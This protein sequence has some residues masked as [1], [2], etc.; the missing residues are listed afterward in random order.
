MALSSIW[1]SASLA[2]RQISLL[3]LVLS[4][5]GSLQLSYLGQ[6]DSGL[7]AQAPEGLGLD[8]TDRCGTDLDFKFWNQL[9]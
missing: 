2:L 9:Q 8:L 4:A 3:Q 1:N 5:S 7:F 6:Q